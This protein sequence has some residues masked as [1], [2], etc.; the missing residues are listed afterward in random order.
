MVVLKL[1]GFGAEP[2]HGVRRES[3]A[4]SRKISKAR[5]RLATEM[6]R[7]LMI[8][9]FVS[10]R[11]AAFFFFKTVDFDLVGLGRGLA[12]YSLASK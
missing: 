7:G 12:W 9:A 6:A 5:A 8:P 3:R 4:M 11:E 10:I 1:G 2:H